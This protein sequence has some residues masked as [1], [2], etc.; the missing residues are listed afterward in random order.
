[1]NWK[2]A[3]EN[4]LWGWFRA[5][6]TEVMLSVV[7]FRYIFSFRFIYFE[8]HR[9]AFFFLCSPWAVSRRFLDQ[10]GEFDAQGYGETP[11]V[12]LNAV[13]R[14]LKLSSSDALLELGSGT[15]RNCMWLSDRYGCRTLGIEQIPLFVQLGKKLARQ[16]MPPG[17]VS[18]ICGDMFGLDMSRWQ[19]VYVDCTAMSES[20]IRQ[21]AMLCAG[22]PNGAKVVTVNASLAQLMPERFQLESTFPGLFIWGWS[23]MRIQRVGPPEESPEE[24]QDQ[25]GDRS[26]P[27]TVTEAQEP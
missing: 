3:R 6:V 17:K 27:L 24:Q 18:F 25:Q 23:D 16:S 12:T 7:G 4:R 11:L 9:R 8:L 19:R 15:G 26:I 10:R 14:R 13:A 22:L 21:V 1:M 20:C 5:L 2:N